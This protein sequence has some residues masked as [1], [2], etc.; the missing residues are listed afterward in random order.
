MG[1]Y[2]GPQRGRAS[3]VQ[4]VGMVCSN[5]L[6]YIHATFRRLPASM[7]PGPLGDCT[8]RTASKVLQNFSSGKET[9]ACILLVLVT[10]DRI[11]SIIRPTSRQPDG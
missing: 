9:R 3:R 6:V 8:C 2:E 11:D 5:T 10:V 4:H 1:A 7:G